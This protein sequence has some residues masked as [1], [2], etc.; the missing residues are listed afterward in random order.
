MKALVT[1]FSASGVTGTVAKRLA[2][3]IGAEAYEIRPAVPYT[4][5]E[6]AWMKKKSR[7]T[8]EMQDKS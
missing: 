4:A 3:A 5:A 8:G 1:Y 6:L 2:D 7:S